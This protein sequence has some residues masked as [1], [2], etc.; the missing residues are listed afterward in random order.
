MRTLP[1]RFYH[2]LAGSV[3]TSENELINWLFL[4]TCHF[5]EICTGQRFEIERFH[6]PFPFTC[7][8][9]EASTKGGADRGGRS[10]GA[11]SGDGGSARAASTRWCAGVLSCMRGRGRK[12]ERGVRKKEIKGG[13]GACD[14]DCNSLVLLL[15][16]LLLLMIVIIAL[17]HCCARR[18]E[19]QP[20]SH[21]EAATLANDPA[22]VALLAVASCSDRV[23]AGHCHC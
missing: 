6:W 8:E 11:G 19:K 3:H 15:L 4:F 22:A 17:L 18:A 13:P 14:V 1:P 21:E 10:C 20:P 12:G 9:K 7:P 2:P 16:L 23:F 5:P